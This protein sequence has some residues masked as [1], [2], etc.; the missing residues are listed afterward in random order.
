MTIWSDLVGIA[1]GTLTLGIGGVCL[2][3]SSGNLALR[4]PADTAAAGLVG[5]STN[6]DAPAGCVGEYVES[7]VDAPSGVSPS[8]STATNVTSITLSAGDWDVSGLIV[9]QLGGSTR[10]SGAYGSFSTVSS[11]QGSDPHVADIVFQNTAVP[12]GNLRFVLPTSRF[13]LAASTTIYL[14]VYITYDTS[15][16]KIGG[17]ISARRMR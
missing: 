9:T 10:V 1:K 6:D 5:T 17:K 8:S 12:T 11:T 7:V 3:N 4:N 16:A 15:T 13:K 14:V 2:K